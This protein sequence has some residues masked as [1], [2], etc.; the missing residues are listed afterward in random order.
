MTAELPIQ[1]EV[2]YSEYDFDARHIPETKKII[3][4]RIN[5]ILCY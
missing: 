5:S 1:C 3:I 2:R 4:I